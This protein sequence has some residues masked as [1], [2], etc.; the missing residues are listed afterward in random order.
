[1]QLGMGLSDDTPVLTIGGWVEHGELRTGDHVYGPDGRSKKILAVTGSTEQDLHRLTFDRSVEIV[2]AGDHLW[3][4]HRDYKL[5]AVELPKGPNGERRR[6][7]GTYASRELAW[8]TSQIAGIPIGSNGPSR[9]FQVDLAAPI[10]LPAQ[11]LTV[12]PYVLGLWLGDG[13][14]H[15]GIIGLDLQD[16][17]E[18]D[19]LGRRVPSNER[20]RLVSVR[21]PGLT[22]ALNNLGLIKNKHIPEA[23]LNGSVEQ[24]LA[25]LQGL[26]DTDGC[27]FKSGQAE[28][29][30]TNFGLADGV[31]WLVTSLGFKYTRAETVGRF[32][33]KEYR[34][35]AKIRF[36]TRPDMPAFRFP[37]KLE[38]QHPSP[39]RE[40]RRRQIQRVEPVGRGSARS[41]TVEGGLYLVGRDLV[42]TYH[43]DG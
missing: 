7:Y 36:S 2:A 32:A 1:M 6:Q 13:N 24:R 14:S 19:L 43:C 11:D 26:M 23:Y 34:P 10:D 40:S 21:I 29:T 35:V 9:S 37:R 16:A 3:L 25:L 17:A 31:A 12:D 15:T 39:S 5:P 30:N 22:A 28:F 38:R 18:L 27:C 20:G 41:I 42:I 8:T 33:G 4:G